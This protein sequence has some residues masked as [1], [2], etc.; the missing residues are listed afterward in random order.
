EVLLELGERHPGLR[1]VVDHLAKP[2]IGLDDREPWQR[3]IADVAK[4][5][6][7]YAKV[8][9]LYAHGEDPAAWSVD[10]M[11]PFIDHAVNVFGFNRLMYGGD[12]PVSM[13]AGD[14]HRVWNGVNEV[15]RGISADE[16]SRL[17]GGTA[18]DFYRLSENLLQHARGA[19]NGNS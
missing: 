9:G 16:H 12:W 8:S 3:L 11:H 10:L 14:Y 1:V 18:S 7:V 15:F 4:N 2:P 5:P 13:L 17:F 6:N 19:Q